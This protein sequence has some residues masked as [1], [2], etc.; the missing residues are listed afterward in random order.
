MQAALMVLLRPPR[1]QIP[2]PLQ[3][4]KPTVQG[5]QSGRAACADISRP[6]FPLVFFWLPLACLMHRGML[7]ICLPTRSCPYDPMLMQPRCIIRYRLPSEPGIFVDVVD[8]EDVRLMFEEIAELKN[9]PG[10]PAPC[11]AENYLADFFLI[12]QGID[13]LSPHVCALCRCPCPAPETASVCRAAAWWGQGFQHRCCPSDH[14]VPT[15]LFLE[16]RL[17]AG[18]GQRR[19][20][21]V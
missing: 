12:S 20:R 7:H 9:I 6:E 13:L 14:D 8:N 21:K 4:K 5:T 10:R 11:Y 2:A 19:R 3:V 18:G 17:A 1:P 16:H 15:G